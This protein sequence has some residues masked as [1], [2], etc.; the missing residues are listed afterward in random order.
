VLLLA[1]VFDAAINQRA[2]QRVFIDFAKQY[3]APSRD[4]MKRSKR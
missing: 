1:E 3:G 2:V 4:V